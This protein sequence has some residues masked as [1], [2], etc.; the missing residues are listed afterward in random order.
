MHRHNRAK[1]TGR[2]EDC[3]QV[4]WSTAE[5]VHDKHGEPFDGEAA[6]RQ[7]IV[8]YHQSGDHNGE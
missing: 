4:S 8:D 7:G 6:V 3:P 1:E 5:V 2:P